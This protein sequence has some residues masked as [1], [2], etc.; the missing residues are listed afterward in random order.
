MVALSEDGLLQAWGNVDP[1]FN[2]LYI[3]I[4][5]FPLWCDHS[6]L[7]F[8]F[9]LHRALHSNCFVDSIYASVNSKAGTTENK[10]AAY[11]N[12]NSV[13]DVVNQAIMNMVSLGEVLPMKAFRG[14][15]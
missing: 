3:S 12:Q 1:T 5:K 13:T 9:T 11:I 2:T 14:L 10:C 4:I 15:V 8:Q 7:Q 6:R